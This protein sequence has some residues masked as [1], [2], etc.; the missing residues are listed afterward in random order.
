MLGLVLAMNE[1]TGGLLLIDEIENGL[2]YSV[3]GEMFS[4]LLDL[5]QS[6]NV[7]IFATTHSDEC[8]KAANQ[9]FAKQ[10]QQEFAYYRLEQINEEIKAVAFDSEML[11]T[12]IARNMEMR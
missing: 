11:E 3:Q 4:I 6:F 5:A 8:I 2:H 1:A 9:A 7:Q 12:A 10:T